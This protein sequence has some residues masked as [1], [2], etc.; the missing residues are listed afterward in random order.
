VSEKER[1]NFDEPAAVPLAAPAASIS[2]T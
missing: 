2:K 1:I